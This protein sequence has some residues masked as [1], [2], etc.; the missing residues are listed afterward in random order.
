MRSVDALTWADLILDH[1]QRYK[2]DTR[3]YRFTGMIVNRDFLN[4]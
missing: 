1:Q 2:I 4:K 3:L